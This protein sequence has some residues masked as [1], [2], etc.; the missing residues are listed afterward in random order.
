[1]MNMVNRARGY[2][3][4]SVTGV[5]PEG[6]I[7]ACAIRGVHFWNAGRIDE[8]TF[9][10]QAARS[11]Y[12][13][14]EALAREQNCALAV[15]RRQGLPFF[16][17]RF[18]KRYALLAGLGLWLL[19][20]GAMGQFIWDIDVRGNAAIPDETLLQ[21]L[22][23]L[24]VRPGR[25]TGDLEEREIKNSMLLNVDG[26]LWCALNIRGGQ[27]TLFVRERTEPEPVVPLKEP[28]DVVAGEAGVLV[29]LDTLAGAARAQSGQTV[30]KGQTLVSGLIVYAEAEP[31]AVHARVY[32]LARTWRDI[33]AVI[34]D[35]RRE[36]RYTGR[37]KT[38]FSLTA[39]G[40]RCNLYRR[41]SLPFDNCDKITHSYTL[42][43]PLGVRFPL[44]LVR[45]TY[46]EYAPEEARVPEAE[47][48]GLL[49]A[50]LTERL[51]REGGE[52]SA[53]RM[54]FENRNGLLGVRATAELLRD[55]AETRYFTMP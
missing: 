38:R 48:A 51:G 28:C 31:R 45:E 16:T 14:L 13:K 6:F 34:P 29:R 1:M 49:E 11:A 35:S 55:I 39:L 20:A 4:L 27:A 47:A 25:Y 8:A 53:L 37:T 36:K 18:R 23:E 2:L 9:R 54:A 46:R 3:E 40:R 17:M 24:G 7:N 43:A 42:D 50:C 41:D 30:E 26:L 15:L 44:R 21:A 12:P 22:A 5:Y 10:F 52:I 32:A 19:C 33:T